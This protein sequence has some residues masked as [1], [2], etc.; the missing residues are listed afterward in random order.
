M[1]AQGEF[2]EEGEDDQNTPKPARAAGS[3]GFASS[4]SRP[5]D[6]AEASHSAAVDEADF[7]PPPPVT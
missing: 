2:D 5:S 6:V 3:P 1:D 4:S 7:V